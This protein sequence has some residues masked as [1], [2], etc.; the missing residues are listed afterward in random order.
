VVSKSV[1][2]LPAIATDWSPVHQFRPREIVIGR[3]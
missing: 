2:V 1:K 3:V